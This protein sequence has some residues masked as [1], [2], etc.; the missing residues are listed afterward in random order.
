MVNIELGMT[1]DLVF[2]NVYRAQ[3]SIPRNR[4]RQPTLPCG[5]VRHEWGCHFSSPGWESIPGLLKRFTNTDS[6]VIPS[7]SAGRAQE[8]S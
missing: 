3:E 1:S 8:A 6:V 4:F 2:V 7:W 5:P